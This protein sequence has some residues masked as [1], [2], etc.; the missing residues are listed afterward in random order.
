MSAES[1]GRET[2][3]RTARPLFERGLTHCSTGNLSIRLD[4]RWLIS[5]TGAS[6]GEL[7]PAKLSRLDAS[8]QH[9]SGDQPTKES[10]PA[11]GD[12]SGTAQQRRGGTFGFD[13]LGRGIGAGRD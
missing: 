2:L 4:D 8:G 13:P 9:V 7:D 3:C 1:V 5:P 10:F 11:S 12:V 6:L